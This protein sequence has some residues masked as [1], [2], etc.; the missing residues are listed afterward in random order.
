MGQD[1]AVSEDSFFKYDDPNVDPVTVNDVMNSIPF[2]RFHYIMI[3]LYISLYLSTSTLAYN[4]AF[5]LLPQAY[6]CPENILDLNGVA[7]QPDSMISSRRI[8]LEFEDNKQILVGL[9]ECTK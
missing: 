6:Q 2:G 7:S 1:G 9:K 3:V 8:L 4:F 5:F